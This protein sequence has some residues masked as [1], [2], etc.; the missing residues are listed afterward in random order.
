MVDTAVDEEERIA[1]LLAAEARA[2]E[3]FDE[4]AARGIIAPGVSE[5]EASDAIRDLAVELYGVRRFWHKR[6]V[7]GGV[8]TL[9]PFRHE[10]PDR[11]L[12]ADDI[13]FADFGLVFDNFEADLGRTFVL[14][15]DPDRLRLRDDLTGVFVA[16][17][18][19]FL[20]H[21]AV[22]GAELFDHVVGLATAA[23]WEFGGP[24][25]GHLIGRYPHDR[26]DGEAI[27][28]YIAPGSDAPMRRGDS[29]GRPCHWILEVHLVDRARSFGGFFEQLLDVGPGPA[30]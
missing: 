29:A 17:R 1:R 14:G 18:R 23:G 8:N 16:A 6:I 5:V 9:L 15:A 27:E 19:Y 30:A 28:S 22:S 11:V 24:H 26:I 7:R 20:E 3:L 13:A 21:P 10:P 25:C 4:V 2:V 12:A